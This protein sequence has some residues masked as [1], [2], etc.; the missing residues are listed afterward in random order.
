MLTV[1][2]P[3]PGDV[4]G[5]S[6]IV[7]GADFLIPPTGNDEVITGWVADPAYQDSFVRSGGL[8]LV[9]NGRARIRVDLTR[10]SRGEY[11]EPKI[12]ING[13]VQE[14]VRLYPDDTSSYKTLYRIIE[15][16]DILTVTGNHPSGS[17]GRLGLYPQRRL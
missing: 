16:G 14:T 13:A 5:S 12:L 7:L 4:I 10:Q 17:G 9:G 2:P 6:R 8:F 15:H 1:A 11:I 3:D